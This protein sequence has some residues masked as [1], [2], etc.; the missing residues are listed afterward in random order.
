MFNYAP[1]HLHLI[2]K[3]GIYDIMKRLNNSFQLPS[4]TIYFKITIIICSTSSYYYYSV[5]LCPTYGHVDRLLI[6]DDAMMIFPFRRRGFPFS[7]SFF[8]RR[9][10]RLFFLVDCLFFVSH[11][12]YCCARIHSLVDSSYYVML[13]KKKRKKIHVASLLH[14]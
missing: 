1:R 10:H 4:S 11:T 5:F 9:R 6:A 12:I 8:Y 3:S 2:D 7:H 14:Y 13:L